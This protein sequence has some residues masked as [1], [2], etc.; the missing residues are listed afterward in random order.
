MAERQKFDELVLKVALER[1]LT[2]IID[3]VLNDRAIIT[4]AILSLLLA[5]D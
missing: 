1:E 3:I 4:P 2:F 5:E